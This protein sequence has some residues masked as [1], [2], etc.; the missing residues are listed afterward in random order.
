M[1]INNMPVC[2]IVTHTSA[3]V[4]E[5]ARIIYYRAQLGL[6]DCCIAVAL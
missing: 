4:S 6:F 1:G 5:R 2:I 3:G